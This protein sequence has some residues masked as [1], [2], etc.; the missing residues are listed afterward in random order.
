MKENGNRLLDNKENNNKK[1]IFL[2]VTLIIL[3][4]IFVIELVS[5][6][7]L[8]VNSGKYLEEDNKINKDNDIIDKEEIIDLEDEVIYFYA[9]GDEL[10]WISNDY[11]YPSNSKDKEEYDKKYQYLGKY[12]CEYD[13]CR[14]LSGAS[15]YA[16]YSYSINNKHVFIYEYNG[17]LSITNP[18][19]KIVVYNFI[20][21]QIENTYDYIYADYVDDNIVLVAKKN[22]KFA[23][24]NNIGEEIS[25]YYDDVLY[26]ERL[27]L[28]QQRRLNYDYKNNFI[29]VYKDNN[30]YGILSFK[31]GQ[32]ITEAIYDNISIY[33]NNI[34]VTK[35]NLDYVANESGN[36]I[37]KGY[38]KIISSNDLVILTV[39]NNML[40][41][42]DY[43]GNSLINE[44]INFDN[45]IYERTKYEG[46]EATIPNK[47]GCT[48]SYDNNIIT[49][50][51]SNN[52][53][54][55][56]NIETKEL[57]KGEA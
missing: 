26:L 33:Q 6:G 9:D 4:I 56:Y 1:L 45:V 2:I 52:I 57:N 37:S 25:S 43:D 21:K 53:K 19:S 18:N 22:K 40:D 46:G 20:D 49:I 13:K 28:G 31:N 30:K 12:D 48:I 55:T 7:I 16:P 29:G 23:I 35:D 38:N 42:I 32:E 14:V 11:V 24:I 41:I 44:E 39:E 50:D 8:K 34:V 54:Y 10:L 3:L 36:I 27:T 47:Y 15:F 5:F 17:E 51:I